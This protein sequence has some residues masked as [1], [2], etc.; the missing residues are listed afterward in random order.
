MAQAGRETGSFGG[1]GGLE[2]HWRAW[3]PPDPARAVVLIAHGAA[4]HSGRYEWVAGRLVER[5]LAVLALDHR[6]HGRSDGPRAYVDRVEH[7]VADLDALARLAADREPGVPLFLLGHSMGGMIALAYAL[8]HQEKLAGLVLSAPLALLPVPAAARLAART[9]GTVAPRLPVARIDGS[10]VSRDPAVVAA[11]DSDPLNHR[12][13]LPARTVAELLATVATF[14]DRL[15]DLR[16]PLLTV[17]GTGDR[18]VDPRAS[19]LV[20]D[21]AGSADK[22]LIAYDGLYHEVLNEPERERV[23]ADVADWIEARIGDRVAAGTTGDA[24]LPSG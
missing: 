15:P 16:L 9:L 8:D 24:D 2:I 14:P 4:E 12:R 17:Y 19:R 18:L 21:R 10:T 6:G 7:A 13:P 11:Y 23:L 22:T 3:S 1:A 5:G 20:D